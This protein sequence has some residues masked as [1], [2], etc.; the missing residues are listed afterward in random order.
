MKSNIKNE[1]TCHLLHKETPS[2]STHDNN[3]KSAAWINKLQP[4]SMMSRIA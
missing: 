1:I 3:R 2:L 4:D